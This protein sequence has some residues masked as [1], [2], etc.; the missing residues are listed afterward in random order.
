MKLEDLLLSQVGTPLTQI[1]R[2]KDQHVSS[3]AASILRHGLVC[4]PVLSRDQKGL[5]VILGTRRIEA[6]RILEEQ[7]P[8]DLPHGFARFKG[9]GK[10]VVCCVVM[11]KVSSTQAR[12]MSFIDNEVNKDLSPYEEARLYDDLSHDY[13]EEQ[14]ADE[15]MLKRAR[16]DVGLGAIRNLSK[17][18]L[19]A[20]EE[21]RLSHAHVRQLTR[22]EDAT[23]REDLLRKTLKEQLPSS[24]LSFLLRQTRDTESLSEREKLLQKIRTCLSEDKDFSIRMRAGEV[25]V[26]GSRKGDRISIDYENPVELRSILERLV[27]LLP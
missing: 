15:L 18:A 10:L 17:E 14:I 20:W 13:P 9:K 1:R 5:H 7:E 19:S 11:E 27:L 25:R 22:V 4:P 21:G 24:A 3:L 12:V 8:R 26:E 6:L 16:V 23:T 2:H